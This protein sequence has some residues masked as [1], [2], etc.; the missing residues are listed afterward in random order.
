MQRTIGG[1]SYHPIQTVDQPPFISARELSEIFGVEPDT[2]GRWRRRGIG[3]PWHRLPSGRV[4]YEKA[5]TLAWM[6]T[7]LGGDQLL[8]KVEGKAGLSQP[9]VSSA[10]E[11][12]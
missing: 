5:A 8:E 1:R 6:K 7:T 11:G 9:A 12:R 4:R 2:L 10:K 3:P